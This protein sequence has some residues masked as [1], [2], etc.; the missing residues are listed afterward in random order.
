[1]LMR[2][3]MV[4]LDTQL[5]ALI[6]TCWFMGETTNSAYFTVFLLRDLNI[7]LVHPWGILRLGFECLMLKAADWFTELSYSLQKIKIIK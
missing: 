2:T 6:K 1:M 3:P 7:K 4:L 5:S